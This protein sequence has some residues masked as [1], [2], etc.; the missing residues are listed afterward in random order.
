[1]KILAEIIK[2]FKTLT[3]LENSGKYFEADKQFIKIANDIPQYQGSTVIQPG[4]K[5]EVPADASNIDVISNVAKTGDP[6]KANIG[7][8]TVWIT[9]GAQG[10]SGADQNASEET[11][12]GDPARSLSWEDRQHRAGGRQRAGDRQGHA[13]RIL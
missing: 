5:Y 8:E 1:M 10:Q 3:E 13:R 7:G 2:S 12:P 11:G 4:Q 6:A 9:H